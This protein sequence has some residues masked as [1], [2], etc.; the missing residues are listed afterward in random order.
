MVDENKKREQDQISLLGTILDN[1]EYSKIDF[2]HFK[3]GPYLFHSVSSH[4]ELLKAFNFRLFVY[5]H[6]ENR[7]IDKALFPTGF[8]FDKYDMVSTH[9]Y[10]INM[11]TETIC[12]YIRLI[13]DTP[14]GL[15]IEKEL[16]VSDYRDSYKI[17]EISRYISHPK[18][19]PFVR[20][21]IHNALKRF[22]KQAGIEK[23]VGES[24]EKY[25]EF[26]KSIGSVP[27]EPYRTW[28]IENRGSDWGIKLKDEKMYGNVIHTDQID[29]KGFSELVAL[30]T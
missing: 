4:S 9:F 6:P 21:G 23:I 24:R 26:F 12:G 28:N 5:S 10:A 16:D 15:Q 2:M 19:Q 11:D 1:I 29:E 30:T 13:N 27:M 3:K 22:A 20:D 14:T 18:K 8:E 7:Y 17:S 25:I